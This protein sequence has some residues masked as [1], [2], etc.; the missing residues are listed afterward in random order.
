MSKFKVN[1]SFTPRGT[2]VRNDRRGGGSSPAWIWVRSKSIDRPLMR[3]GVPVLNRPALNPS[4]R[5]LSL[6][7]DAAS[8][9]R[10]P[11]F[12]CSPTCSSPR[13]NV[14]AVNTT[15]F[16]L[17]S[18]PKSVDTPITSPSLTIS[19]AAVPCSKFKFGVSSKIAFNRN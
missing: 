16:A 10:P 2:L 4:A 7:V 6:S 13:K 18:T 19:V 11:A 5:I 3:Q 9:I 1:R 12:E 8:P 17:I 15:V 14:P